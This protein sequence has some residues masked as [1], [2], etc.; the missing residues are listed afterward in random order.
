MCGACGGK[1]PKNLRTKSAVE[2]APT[3]YP[4]PTAYEVTRLINEAGAAFVIGITNPMENVDTY[5]TDAKKAV[6]IGIYGADLAYVSTYNLEQATRNYIKALHTLTN[7]LHIST[8]INNSLIQQIEQNIDNKD[9]V[10]SIISRSFD[11]TYS[12]LVNNGQDDVSLLVLAGTWIEGMYI[13]TYLATT[14][15]NAENLLPIVARQLTSLNTLLDLLNASQNADIQPVA[16]K[17]KDI[18][19]LFIEISDQKAL[20]K[21]GAQQLR[22]KIEGLRNEYVAAV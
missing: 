20:D 18:Q 1:Q 13:A 4:I 19:S 11:D 15:E 3:T 6:N 14:S 16:K 12:F 21:K 10:I 8:Q 2:Q 22:D 9:T 7:D 17:I 5:L